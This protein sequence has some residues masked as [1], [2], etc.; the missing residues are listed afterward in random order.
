M[1]E[2]R[3]APLPAGWTRATL[4]E[5][6]E[7]RVHQ[8]PPI[9]GEIPYIDISSIDR[10]T[11][12]VGQTQLVNPR[13]APSRARQWVR[14]GDVL[15][16]MT[17]PNLNVVALVPPALDGAV[18]STGFDVLRASA[19]RPEWLYYRVRSNAFVA[20]VCEGLQ[21][22]VYPAIRPHDVRRHEIPIPPLPEQGR[23]IEAT[24]FC[25]SRID[26]AEGLLERVRCNLGRY[27]AAILKAA[28]GQGND[29]C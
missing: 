28:V 2:N 4:A 11:K 14:T 7:A 29:A 13:T 25:F 9:K 24:Q 19:V 17:R 27:R 8:S 16:S 23:I 10:S 26:E 18:A 1:S 12:V 3:I 22:V 15:V 6:T 21:G 20:D 5:V